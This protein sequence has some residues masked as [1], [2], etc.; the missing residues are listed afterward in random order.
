MDPSYLWKLV[1]LGR[2]GSSRGQ[3]EDDFADRL[4]YQFTTVL[5]MLCVAIVSLR[6]YIGKIFKCCL[7][8]QNL[9]AMTL[10]A[11]KM[12]LQIFN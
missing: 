7:S 11:K 9:M 5:I 8:K 1:S 10:N 6:Q 12:L 4:H 3:P 2:L